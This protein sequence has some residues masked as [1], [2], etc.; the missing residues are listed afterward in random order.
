MNV[1]VCDD[2]L[3][4]RTL[5]CDLLKKSGCTIVGEA[6]TGAAAVEQYLRLKPD[7]VTMDIVMPFKSGIEATKEILAFDDKACIVMCS[8]LGQESLVMEAIEAGAADFI[9]KVE[10][11]TLAGFYT[12]PL[13]AAKPQLKLYLGCRRNSDLI[14]YRPMIGYFYQLKIWD[15][16]A[17]SSAQL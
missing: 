14:C 5:L 12:D 7:V 9:V 11:V 6:D 10:T 17:L 1:L 16:L 4:M 13:P 8:A 2:A 3:F 15:S